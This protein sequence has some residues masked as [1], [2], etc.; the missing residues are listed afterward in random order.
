MCWTKIETSSH[1]MMSKEKR[2]EQPKHVRWYFFRKNHLH[3]TNNADPQEMRVL[4]AARK[5][6]KSKKAYNSWTE[7]T[8]EGDS[9][10]SRTKIPP[11]PVTNCNMIFQNLGGKSQEKSRCQQKHQRTAEEGEGE[12]EKPSR[13]KIKEVK[14]KRGEEEKDFT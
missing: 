11:L 12:R 9:E 4:C 13:T 1:V 3:E 10:P 14:R 6:R 8:R 5:D 7:K 2:S